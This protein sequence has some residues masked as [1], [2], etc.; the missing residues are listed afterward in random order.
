MKDKM[1]QLNIRL[2]E[3]NFEILN[4]ISHESSQ[5]PSTFGSHIVKQWIEFYYC[6]MRRGDVIFSQSIL[7][8]LLDALDKSHIDEISEFMANYII[9]EIKMQEGNVDY[10]VLV[11]HILKWNKANHLHMSIIEKTNHHNTNESDI[12]TSRHNLG[13]NWSEMECKTYKRVF[14]MIGRTILSSE[15]DDDTFSFE[16]IKKR[17][18][19]S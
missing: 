10:S 17:E 3:K 18:L 6:K 12:F 2:D 19:T 14:E 13:G 16:V 1:H 11:D 7:R 4:K 5:S 15:Y 9:K 8:K